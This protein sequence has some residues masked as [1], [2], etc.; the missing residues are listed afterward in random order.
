MSENNQET[1]QITAG[2]VS[3]VLLSMAA[4]AVEY[5]QQPGVHE[6]FTEWFA[7]QDE[8]KDIMVPDLTILQEA[9]LYVLLV[10]SSKLG[11]LGAAIAEFRE[12][13]VHGEG[14]S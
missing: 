8:N 1:P 9:E 12:S 3:G 7:A 10:S 14:A 2:Q 4:A 13:A 6:A 11:V 5:V